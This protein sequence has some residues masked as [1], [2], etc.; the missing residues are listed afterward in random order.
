M[1]LVRVNQ[2]NLMADI[3][4]KQINDKLVKKEY[5][6]FNNLPSITNKNMNYGDPE[7]PEDPEQVISI[8]IMLNIDSI[9]SMYIIYT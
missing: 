2:F 5:I 9:I 1:D 4:N 3:E 6:G 8:T 7:D